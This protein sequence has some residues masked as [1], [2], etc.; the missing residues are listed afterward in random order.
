MR[1]FRTAT[2]ERI[3]KNLVADDD[4]DQRSNPFSEPNHGAPL[5][6]FC[7]RPS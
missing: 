3:K 5:L 7:N 4:Y 1:P 6:R 2:P